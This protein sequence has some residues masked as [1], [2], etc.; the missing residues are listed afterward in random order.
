T[1]ALCA[2]LVAPRRLRPAAAVLGALLAVAVA[3]AILIL[4]W[5]FPSDVLGGFLVATMWVLLLVAAL[6]AAERRR[7]E[8]PPAAAHSGPPVLWPIELAGGAAL[9][10]LA[11]IALAR[12]DDVVRDARDDVDPVARRCGRELAPRVHPGGDLRRGERRPRPWPVRGENHVGAR[13]R[14]PRRATDDHDP[15]AQ[16]RTLVAAHAREP[17][18]QA[19][20]APRPHGRRRT[21]VERHDRD[22]R[23]A[24]GFQC[25]PGCQSG[26]SPAFAARLRMKSRSDRRLR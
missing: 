20:A 13:D 16:P 10:V 24:C 23:T 14:R 9:A 8:A 5:H 2:V 15:R 1:L 7:P 17:A 6:L 26:S 12:P 4:A 3:Y 11:A 22:G 25:C 21:L 18:G 19:R